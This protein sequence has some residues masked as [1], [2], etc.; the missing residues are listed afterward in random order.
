[1]SVFFDGIRERPDRRGW[2]GRAHPYQDWGTAV[3]RLAGAL[4][5]AQRRR[6]QENYDNALRALQLYGMADP[7]F[8][9]DP[10]RA[11]GLFAQVE[12]AARGMRGMGG[13]QFPREQVPGPVTQQA[14]PAQTI[15]VPP[16]IART[17]VTPEER[18]PQATTPAVPPPRGPSSERIALP[19]ADPMQTRLSA[20]SP[21][22]QQ[23]IRA[24]AGD[25]W[26]VISDMT[27]GEAVQFDPSLSWALRGGTRGGGTVGDVAPNLRN[28]PVGGY[29]A[30]A[31]MDPRT[32]LPDPAKINGWA[33]QYGVE[34]MTP[35]EQARLAQGQGT[36]ARGQVGQLR[37]TINGLV[38]RAAEIARSGDPQAQQKAHAILERA[39]DVVDKFRAQNP[40]ADTSGIVIPDSRDLVVQKPPKTAGAIDARDRLAIDRWQHVLDTQP[41]GSAAAK[42]AASELRI[43]YRRNGI[44]L[45]PEPAA[46][47][48]AGRGKNVDD[49]WTEAGAYGPDVVD[50]MRRIAAGQA[51]QQRSAD[52]THPAAYSDIEIVRT[53]GATSLL[54]QIIAAQ[55]TKGGRP[56]S[57]PTSPPPGA[58]PGGYWGTD[59]RTGQRQYAVGL[60]VYDESGKIVHRPARTAP[61]APATPTAPAGPP[62]GSA[63]TQVTPDSQGLDP[64][65]YDGQ[66]VQAPDGSV[67]ESDGTTWTQVQ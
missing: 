56:T 19:V 67:W 10:E 59:P 51:R 53:A 29:P 41:E 64:A 33:R 58:P 46:R 44:E 49:L 22:L 42:R 43:L 9:R 35:Y 8:T 13:F 36:A 14:V 61:A 23:A 21:K 4:V 15:A 5:A 24:Q 63:P 32:G 30:Y 31:V 7:G 65:D 47:A 17:G 1:M 60:A 62:Q 37:G 2:F 66:Q 39:H 25:E 50:A 16:G 18:A 3:G 6:Q 54:R 38:T 45:E 11:R 27:L 20:L 26:D 57:P 48:S 55:R 34:P 12:Q 52:K 40:D 28:T